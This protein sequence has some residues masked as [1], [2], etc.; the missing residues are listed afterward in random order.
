MLKFVHT[1]DVHIKSKG[2]EGYSALEE[3]LKKT[4]ESGAKALFITGD[5]FE[6]D[7]ASFAV[8]TDIKELFESFKEINVFLIRGNHDEK[9][10]PSNIN[11]G[12]NSTILSREP[13]EKV[14]Y[15]GLSIYGVP[16]KR[17]EKLT[18]TLKEISGSIDNNDNLKLLLLHGTL[19]DRWLRDILV[20]MKDY[21]KDTDSFYIHGDE[22]EGSALDLV[23]MGHYHKYTEK[24]YGNTLVTYCGSPIATSIK[25]SG[26]RRASLIDVDKNRKIKISPITL[27]SPYIVYEIFKAVPGKEQALMEEIDHFVL[28]NKDDK[29]VCEIKVEG[30]IDTDEKK[31]D[32]KIKKLKKDLSKSFKS[33]EI[34][35]NTRQVR[36]LHD[37]A[38]AYEF[39]KIW[40]AKLQGESKDPARKEI[41]HRALEFALDAFEESILKKR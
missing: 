39:L 12:E 4:S 32:S 35:N 15:E 26:P 41:Y 7:E 14:D 16:F 30:Y 3:I 18:P 21:E 28:K 40:E 36:S 20:F 11:Y 38:I 1:A 2:D 13:F 5:L 9:S 10:Y 31:F 25:N 37:N 27:S 17:G 22:L 6:S 34:K 19:I 8:R 33:M 23:L 29:A 24:N